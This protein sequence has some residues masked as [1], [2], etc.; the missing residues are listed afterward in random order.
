MQLRLLGDPG[1]ETKGTG[2]KSDPP[3]FGAA[4]REGIYNRPR[5]SM[6]RWE[7]VLREGYKSLQEARWREYPLSKDT[8]SAMRPCDCNPWS[9]L[10]TG[11][12]C[13]PHMD[14]TV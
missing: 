9:Q 14:R 3:G 6:Q 13:L 8:D 5:G 11:P 10:F 2:C 12:G 7:C 1:L 4:K